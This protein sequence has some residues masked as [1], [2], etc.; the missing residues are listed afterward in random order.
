MAL[1][2]SMVDTMDNVTRIGISL[3]P[4]LLKE[5]DDLVTGR[6]YTNRSEAIRDLIRIAL[7]EDRWE[8]SEADVVGT[9][10]LVYDHGKG[11]AQDRLMEIQHQHH[12]NISS[13][14][15]LHLSLD[16][17]LEVL[18]VWGKVKEVKHLADEIISINGVSF[19]KLTMTSG[20]MDRTGGQSGKH[21]HAH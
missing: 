4:D 10:T 7:T 20:S 17:C 2:P 15:H 3:E 16:Q 12:A 13:T 18:I 8:D 21:A 6:G 19:G 1:Y 14:I 9:I 11:C 5:F